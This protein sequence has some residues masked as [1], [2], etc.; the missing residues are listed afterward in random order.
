MV[1]IMIDKVYNT[2]R[3]TWCWKYS[4]MPMV[5]LLNIAKLFA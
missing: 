3:P 2:G 4:H 5:V 1:A